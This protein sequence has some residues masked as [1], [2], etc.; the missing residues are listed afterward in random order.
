MGGFSFSLLDGDQREAILRTALEVLGKTG[1]YVE[2]ERS[3]ATLERAGARRSGHEIRIDPAMVRE[4]VAAAPR[5]VT[6]H[7][8][9]GER[10][11]IGGDNKYFGSLLHDP[12]VADYREGLRAPRLADVERNAKL[13]DA[14]PLVHFILKLDW[15]SSDGEGFELDMVRTLRAMM[16]NSGKAY[17]CFPHDLEKLQVWLDMCGICNDGKPL[18]THPNVIF[19]VHIDHPLRFK[20]LE[21]DLMAA[22]VERGLPVGLMT[23][24][25]AGS[26]APYT[27]AGTL[28]MS[29]AANL[30]ELVLAQA[31]RPGAPCVWGGTAAAHNFQKDD[32]SYGGLERAML[33]VGLAEM[34]RHL[35]LP[36]SV[37]PGCGTEVSRIDVQCGIESTLNNMAAV[38]GPTHMALGLGS[39]AEG[40]GMGAEKI[41][42]D[43]EVIASLLRVRAGINTSEKYLAAAA[44]DRV[45]WAQGQPFKN[46]PLTHELM[47]SGEHHYGTIFD[48]YAMWA[49]MNWRSPRTPDDFDW[50]KLNRKTMLERAHEKVEKLIAG[51]KSTVP[52]SRIEALDSYVR[53]KEETLR[54]GSLAVSR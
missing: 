4:A 22:I 36:C 1:F 9:N 5:Q 14:L 31:I 32:G 15:Q 40:W 27:L 13:A 42:I 49:I 34:A 50:D 16:A 20:H 44:I 25:F 41:L 52:E 43:H 17:W 24:F 26:I 48:R 51:H 8:P 35:G 38:F 37:S 46:D 3:C 39:L 33:S 30:L 2:N 19:A 29:T 28:A 53:E 23:Q 45:G 47:D 21:G 11:Q 7:A 18:S 12:V 6:L 54:G 10:L